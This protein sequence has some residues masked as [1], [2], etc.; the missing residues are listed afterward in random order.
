MKRNKKIIIFMGVLTLIV[1][2]FIVCGALFLRFREEVLD[3]KIGNIPVE[4]L[5]LKF[6]PWSRTPHAAILSG[7]NLNCRIGEDHAIYLNDVRINEFFDGLKTHLSGM[8]LSEIRV[9]DCRLNSGVRIELKLKTHSADWKYFDATLKSLDRKNPFQVRMSCSPDAPGS[10]RIVLSGDYRLPVLAKAAQDFKLMQEIPDLKLT[11]SVSVN[12]ELTVNTGNGSIKDAQLIGHLKAAGVTYRNL[13]FTGGDKARFTMKKRDGRVTLGATNLLFSAP[14]TCKLREFSLV[15]PETGG[16]TANFSGSGELL[17][18]EKFGL[19]MVSSSGLAGK[20]NGTYNLSNKLWT[21]WSESGKGGNLVLK[22]G[23]H[24]A[25]LKTGKLEWSG[26]G[27]GVGSGSFSLNAEVPEAM[28]YSPEFRRNFTGCALALS[29]KFGAGTEKPEINGTLSIDKALGDGLELH[30]FHG[31][32]KGEAAGGSWKGQLGVRLGSGRFDDLS[33]N[34][35]TLNG[36]LTFGA[37]E[38]YFKGR[39]AAAEHTG[40]VKGHSIHWKGLA[41]DIEVTADAGNTLQQLTVSGKAVSAKSGIFV[42][43]NPSG[44]VVLSNGKVSGGIGFI[45]SEA[46]LGGRKFFSPDGKITLGGTRA[47]LECALETPELWYLS[48]H[49]SGKLDQFKLTAEVLPGEVIVKLEGAEANAD[50]KNIKIH[51]GKIT[52]N[53]LHSYSQALQRWELN[54]VQTG[55]KVHDLEINAAAARAVIPVLELSPDALAFRNADI[56]MGHLQLQKTS[57]Q[58]KLSGEGQLNITQFVSGDRRHGAVKAITLL[59]EISWSLKGGLQMPSLNKAA[60]NFNGVLTWPGLRPELELNYRIPGFT[61]S[62]PVNLVMLNPEW[63]DIWFGGGGSLHGKLAVN[64]ETLTHA[65]EAELTNASLTADRWAAD[66]LN[67]KLAFTDLG[68]N[69]TQPHQTLSF[70]GMVLG[71]VELGSG[72][73]IFHSM[74]ADKFLLEHA[75]FDCLGGRA[76]TAGPCTIDPGKTPVKLEF[77]GTGLNTASLL[78][79]LGIPETAGN[80]KVSGSLP[81]EFSDHRVTFRNAV[82]NGVNGTIRMRNLDKFNNAAAAAGLRDGSVPF[83]Q[84]VLQ[85][86]I[87][88]E[89]LLT[90]NPGVVRI[91]G[92]GRPA[93]NVPYRYD[94]AGKRFVKVDP[95]DGIGSELELDTEIRP[96]Q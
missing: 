53:Y 34:A 45:R 30:K 32:F 72:E 29:G 91:Q 75:A 1:M 47:D 83:I 55:L 23:R 49:L 15:M 28:V 90:V 66:R 4:K 82:L 39:L 11:G 88:R 16:Q 68:Q 18:G 74:A 61:L 65:A 2:A 41:A 19:E 77:T 50:G 60:L 26:S 51:A 40:P 17:A 69:L 87:Y 12:G 80:S 7:L 36:N 73:M 8:N 14:F 22:H 25:D 37:A 71:G 63:K 79:L 89:L 31:E 95:I 48:E 20:F 54:R 81:V 59:D 44:N 38:R 33:G 67:A 85:D 5:T 52:G 10:M 76:V 64:A 78:F 92:K 3:Q 27:S 56:A 58:Q 93:A 13:A 21:A 6:K 70:G 86:F 84:S 42:L 43:E 9:T 94:S 96:G 35:L 46:D 62:K 57:L 24:I